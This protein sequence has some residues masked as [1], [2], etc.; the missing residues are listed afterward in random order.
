MQNHHTL[1]FWSTPS[2]SITH[3]TDINFQ[4]A[5]NEHQQAKPPSPHHST[6]V[7]PNSPLQPAGAFT[8]QMRQV[9]QVVTG[10]N[11]EL[12]DEVLGRA[13]EIA[14]VLSRVLVLRPAEV[15][16][17][18][19]GAGSLEPLEAGLGLGLGVGVEGALA[20]ELVRRYGL[21][22]AELG[23]GVFL[24]IVWKV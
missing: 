19:D 17:G 18:R 21:L 16:V 3:Y 11:T 22:G 9:L 2:T 4:R 8:Q 10:R 15:G 7:I 6:Q 14:V 12:A 13:L 20:E 1:S 5:H 23:A 24:F